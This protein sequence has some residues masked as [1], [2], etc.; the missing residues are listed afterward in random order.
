M[1]DIEERFKDM[2]FCPNCESII[3]KPEK[4]FGEPSKQC[5]ICG[6]VIYEWL[7]DKDEYNVYFRVAGGT[8]AMRQGMR[9]WGGTKPL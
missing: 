5:P 1:T 3:P 6:A 9:K 7:I 8:G 2:M 4:K